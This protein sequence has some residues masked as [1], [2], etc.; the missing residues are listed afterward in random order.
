[1]EEFTADQKARIEE[2]RRTS[3]E[4]LEERRRIFVADQLEE[5]KN[6]SPEEFK[7]YLGRIR[8]ARTARVAAQA[9]I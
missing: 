2:F 4:Q 7:E 9:K 3:S 5:T 8:A 6:L 1:M